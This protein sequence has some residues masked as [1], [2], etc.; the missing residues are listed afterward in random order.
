M[1]PEEFMDFFSYQRQQIKYVLCT[2]WLIIG[3]GYSF[4]SSFSFI[5]CV[6]ALYMHMCVNCNP[7]M[8]ALS[9]TGS[10][11][12]VPLLAGRL[13]TGSSKH[14]FLSFALKKKKEAKT[15]MNLLKMLHREVHFSLF[16]SLHPSNPKNNLQ[17]CWKT[18]HQVWTQMQSAVTYGGTWKQTTVPGGPWKELTHHASTVPPSAPQQPADCVTAGSN[19]ACWSLSSYTLLPASQHP[20]M[21]QDW[22]SPPSRLWRRALPTRSDRAARRRWGCWGGGFPH[23]GNRC[24]KIQPQ[25]CKRLELYACG[26]PAT[27]SGKWKMWDALI[28]KD[29]GINQDKW[30]TKQT[31]IPRGSNSPFCRERGQCHSL[32][33]EGRSASSWLSFSH[34]AFL[35]CVPIIGLCCTG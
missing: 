32:C 14:F 33:W 7:K 9:E 28:L 1:D 12:I 19:S 27:L 8:G 15:S 2:L 11:Y 21:Q 20:T 29:T 6:F 16:F 13:Q 26:H 24:G 23:H 18:I 3:E 22:A 25:L 31:D 35:H 30:I 5:C 17:G 4:W 10:N 34:Y